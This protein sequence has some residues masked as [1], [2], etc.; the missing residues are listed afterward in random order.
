MA[1]DVINAQSLHSPAGRTKKPKF[2]HE[3]IHDVESLL[4]VL[5]RLCI[6]RKGP[7]INMRR[8]DE[9]DKKSPS[10]NKDLREAVVALFEGADEVLKKKK[11]SLHGDWESFEGE[12]I[13]HFHP[14]F[15]PLKP[16]VRRWW[17]TLILGYKY[18]AEEFYDI[19]DHIIRILDEAIQEIGKTVSE[20]DEATKA[21]INRRKIHKERLL[22]TFR[23]QESVTPPLASSP[24][25]SLPS[26]PQSLR[27]TPQRHAVYQ[28][29]PESPSERLHVPKKFKR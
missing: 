26:S 23:R 19:H 7:G 4:W 9:L 28:E 21:E 13:A 16:Y 15:E 18:R 17:T 20:D 8:E 5:V 10:Y 29:D 27:N 22:A 6:T 2:V 14:Y 25:S 11:S 12:V 1:G 24:L 3:A